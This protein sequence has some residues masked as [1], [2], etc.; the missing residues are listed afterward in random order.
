LNKL[1]HLGAL[2]VEHKVEFAQVGVHG[3]CDNLHDLKMYLESTFI[4]VECE[5]SASE[6]IEL[7]NK[8]IDSYDSVSE[9]LSSSQHWIKA[10][11]EE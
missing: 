11:V 4:K 2:I 8:L 10:L 9:E 3:M 1:E 7:V 5:I 6:S